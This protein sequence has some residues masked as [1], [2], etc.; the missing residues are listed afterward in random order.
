M[1]HSDE[2]QN[3]SYSFSNDSV[4]S[5]WDE[6]DESDY[7]AASWVPDYYVTHC[8]SCNEKFSISLR[9]HHC[10]NCGQVFCYKCADQFHPLPNHNLT[11]PVRICHSCKAALDRD[12]ANKSQ[13]NLKNQFFKQQQPNNQISNFNSSTL[14]FSS[15][16]PNFNS[17]FFSTN[18]KLNNNNNS[19]PTKLLL[20]PINLQQK[21]SN[22]QNS[23]STS[24]S[25]HSLASTYPSTFNTQ[26]KSNTNMN[27]SNTSSNTS[28]CNINLGSRCNQIE[29]NKFKKNGNKT[30]K[31]SV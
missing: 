24:P 21:S 20:N 30:Q 22:Q 31:V 14:I 12:N 1:N 25:N 29:S 3:N 19:N 2:N 15:T 16:P 8:Q 26:A 23:F 4:C 10:R 13:Y 7:K 18:L 5:S 27:L 28:N 6:I 17:D 9:K 11:A